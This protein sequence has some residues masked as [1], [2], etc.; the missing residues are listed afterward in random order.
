MDKTTVRLVQT[1]IFKARGRENVCEYTIFGYEKGAI[2]PGES[3]S[4]HETAMKIP[5]LPPSELP[6]CSN[7]EIRYHIEVGQN[8]KEFHKKGILFTVSSGSQWYWI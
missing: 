7:I 1:I 6:H 5:V 8:Y 2:E 3:D 4:W